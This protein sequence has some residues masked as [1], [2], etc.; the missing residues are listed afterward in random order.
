M[1]ITLTIPDSALEA[2]QFRVDLFNA[3]SGQDPLTIEE[4]AQLERDE[5]TAQRVA[6]HAAADN[7]ALATDE[8]LLAL[9]RAVKSQP[10][11]FPAVKAAVM[12]AL[13][14]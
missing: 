4:F 1:N 7:A 14:S 6:A 2:E 9:G 8:E 12:K 3:G 10:E 13:Q 5:V 11:K